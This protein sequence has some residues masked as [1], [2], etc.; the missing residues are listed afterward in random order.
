MYELKQSGNETARVGTKKTSFAVGALVGA[1]IA[2]LLAPSAGRDVRRRLGRTAKRFGSGA[3][4]VI[5]KARQT[6]SGVR[7][8]ARVSMERGRE[9]FAHTLPHDRPRPHTPTG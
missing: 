7:E 4:D 5:G 2:L 1:G 9:T 3:K 6:V 8:D